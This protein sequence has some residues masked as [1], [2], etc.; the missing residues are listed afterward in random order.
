MAL[1]G[2]LERFTALF[3]QVSLAVLVLQVFTRKDWR[4]LLVAIGYHLIVDAVAVVG[5]RSGWPMLMT[6][7]MIAPFAFISLGIIL[8]LRPCGERLASS[9]LE[10]VLIAGASG[11]PP[12]VPNRADDLNRQL[13][14]SKYI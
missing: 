3:V 8:G 11:S 6:E 4:W 9:G 13:E 10:P 7:V 14:Q 5:V 2:T 12:P 1:L